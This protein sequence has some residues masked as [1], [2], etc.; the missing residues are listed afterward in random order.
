MVANEQA[1]VLTDANGRVVAAQLPGESNK[2]F[3]AQ[4]PAGRLAAL[5]GQRSFE[6]DIPREVLSLPGA[7]LHR[8]LSEMKIHPDGHV[9]LPQ[10]TVKRRDQNKDR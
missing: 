1:I 9:E 8:Y 3:E 5:P 2:V 6:I 4:A 7:D 10:L